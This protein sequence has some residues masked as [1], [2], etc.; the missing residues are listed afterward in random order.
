MERRRLVE[1][2]HVEIEDEQLRM[3]GVEQRGQFLDGAE[4]ADDKRDA[5]AREEF[6]EPA[7]EKRSR[8]DDNGVNHRRH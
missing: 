2:L 7:H 5:A 1:P 8:R 3:L 4:R 6:A